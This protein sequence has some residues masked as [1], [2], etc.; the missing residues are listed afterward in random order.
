VTIFEREIFLNIGK[1][2]NTLAIKSAEKKGDGITF[3]RF[4]LPH[5]GKKQTTKPALRSLRYNR[6]EFN[7]FLIK[8]LKLN[9]VDNFIKFLF[10]FPPFFVCF[11][12]IFF[13][14]PVYKDKN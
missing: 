9:K 2:R 10:V 12:R 11:S 14:F 6:I 8:K 1:N 7:L 13:D 5:Y 3:F 4:F